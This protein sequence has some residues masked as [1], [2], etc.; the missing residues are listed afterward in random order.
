NSAGIVL[1]ETT[2]RQTQFN[3]E[4]TPLTNRCRKAMQ[5]GS[6]IDDVVKVL[7]EKNNGLYTNEWLLGD[8]NTN[9]IAMLELGT[10][11]HKLHRS[12]KNEWLMKGAEGFYWGCN[13]TK[14]EEVRIDAI[15]SLVGRPHDLSWRPSDRDKVWLK[16]FEQNHGK[17]DAEFGKRAFATPPL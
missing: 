5:Y 7:V 10:N 13:N 4:G 2:L 14:C 6:T 1:T 17:I 15:T 3:G 11:Q 8:A 9:E 12:G 16:L